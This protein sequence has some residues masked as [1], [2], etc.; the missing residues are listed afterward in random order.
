MRVASRVAE[1]LK[2]LVWNILWLIVDY[3]LSALRLIFNLQNQQ[4]LNQYNF[5]LQKW[6]PGSRVQELI[7]TCLFLFHYTSDLQTKMENLQDLF[8]SAESAEKWWNL[9]LLANKKLAWQFSELKLML[10]LKYYPKL[11]KEAHYLKK[12][13][14]VLWYNNESKI[15]QF[16]LHY[17]SSINNKLLLDICR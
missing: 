2:N 14:G 6:Q 17:T 1:Q 5:L 15:A 12:I 7:K 3:F 11:N 9:I 13:T 4:K 8:E 10:H 16:L